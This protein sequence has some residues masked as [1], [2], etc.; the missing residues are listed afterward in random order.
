MPPGTTVTPDDNYSERWIGWVF[1][2][3]PGDWN[4]ITTSNDGVRL[5]VNET[6]II[7]QW[8]QHALQT[9]TGTINLDRGWFPIELEH[10][11]QGGTA[12]ITLSFSGPNQGP[13]IIP[14]T[15]L[16]ATSPFQAPTV[17]AGPDQLVLLPQNTATLDGD[18]TDDGVIVSYA[19][20]QLNG[21]SIATLSGQNTDHLTATDLVLGT[22]VFELTAT[23][24]DG[25]TASDTANVIVAD[26]M[27]DHVI[28]GELKKWHKVT[29][30]FDGPSTK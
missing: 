20:S 14:S 3:T 10:F 19:W 1:I 28:T 30:T 5:W 17:H 22:Y 12:E 7:S 9:D 16:R 24:D 29:I 4:F 11:Q 15:R 13:G 25:N 23:D 18:A 2:D 27:G 21:P 6:E 26:D 8:N